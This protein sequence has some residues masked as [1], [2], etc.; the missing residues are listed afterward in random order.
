LADQR[1]NTPCR[2]GLAIF[3][4]RFSVAA[5]ATLFRFDGYDHWIRLYCRYSKDVQQRGLS[6]GSLRFAFEIA[7]QFH[8][9]ECPGGRAR[10][11]YYSQKLSLEYESF[12]HSLSSVVRIPFSLTSGAG[13]WSI[14]PSLTVRSRVSARADT[15]FRVLDILLLAVTDVP[16]V[17]WGLEDDH[18]L[19]NMM[20]K[21]CSLVL[22]KVF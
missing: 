3:P 5:A 22:L 8:R 4:S 6:L 7:G 14:S 2:F 20:W 9:P 11:H 12:Q 19:S 18:E 16:R 1:Y 17:D 15:A 21:F 10:Q 13:G